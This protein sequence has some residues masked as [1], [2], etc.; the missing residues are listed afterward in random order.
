[1]TAEVTARFQDDPSSLRRI[2]DTYRRERLC[3]AYDLHDGLAQHLSGALMHVQAYRDWHVEAPEKAEDSWERGMRLL[4][5]GLRELRQII[6]GL[7]PP[8]VGECGIVERVSD[9]VQGHRDDY[10]LDIAFRHDLRTGQ[11]EPPLANAIFRMIQETLTNAC[12]HS[13]SRRIRLTIVQRGDRLRVVT[14]DWG[15]GFKLT[16]VAEGHY[17]LRGI[18]ERARLFGGEATIRSTL[19]SGT[20]IAVDLPCIEAVP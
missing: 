15:V 5:G 20:R 4:R 1:M 10:G 9:L 8:L 16:D 2:I 19:G 13:R 17:G 14:R 18:R 3:L 11:L 12:R 7:Q 6:D